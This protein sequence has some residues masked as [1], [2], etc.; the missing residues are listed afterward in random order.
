LI[1]TP[2]EINRDLKSGTGAAAGHRTR[3]AGDPPAPA[4]GRLGRRRLVLGLLV[5]VLGVG[6]FLYLRMV[7]ADRFGSYYDDTI[8]VTAAKSLATGEGYRIISLPQPVAQTLIP[9]FYP[10]VLS[11]IWRIYP[12]FP[13]N[14]VWMMLFSVIAMMGFL[15]LSWR[16]LV[17]NAYATRWQ[18]LAVVT[19]TAINWRMISLATSIVSEVLFALLSVAA[20]HLAE[21]Y[22]EERSTWRS[23][24]ILG[25]I[26]GLVCLTRWQCI[27]CTVANGRRSWYRFWLPG[28]LCSGGSGGA[29]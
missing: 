22:K 21:K 16:Y 10:F 18:A 11:V 9:P 27:T 14:L 25:L 7:S 3:L 12:Q 2:H 4:Q 5:L 28:C 24:A 26:A 29:I 20:L 6:F 1:E 13:D 17:K 15:L 23:G 8:Y 19:L